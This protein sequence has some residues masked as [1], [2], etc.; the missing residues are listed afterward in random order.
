MRTFLWL[1]PAILTGCVSSTETFTQDGTKGHVIACPSTGGLVG[2][3]T[4]WGTCF[5]KAGEI[6][7]ANGYTVLQRSD[8]PGFTMA[9]GQYGGGA[10]STANRMMIVRCN[11]P[12]APVTAQIK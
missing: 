8:E 5:Q 6:C 4:N 3:M 12:A 10:S 11:P 9:V 2:A 7:G 1:L